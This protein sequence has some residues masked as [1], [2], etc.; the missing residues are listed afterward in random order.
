MTSTSASGT[1]G[2]FFGEAETDDTECCGLC[3]WVFRIQT[4]TTTNGADVFLQV[5]LEEL[6]NARA[7]V[8]GHFMAEEHRAK[9]NRDT[10]RAGKADVPKLRREEMRGK[11]PTTREN[12]LIQQQF[13]IA[14]LKFNKFLNFSDANE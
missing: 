4:N 2:K 9:P 1:D 10:A 12:S 11:Q 8:S 13:A 6:D 5:V 14:D 3:P 7:T